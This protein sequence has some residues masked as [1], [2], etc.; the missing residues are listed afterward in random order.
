MT[1]SRKELNAHNELLELLKKK[2]KELASLST[3]GDIERK[4]LLAHNICLLKIQVNIE[5]ALCYYGDYADIYTLD[6]EQILDRRN[7]R[8][9]D[10]TI[11]I[12][13]LTKSLN[14]LKLHEMYLLELNDSHKLSELE[15][16]QIEIENTTRRIA[17][18]EY[19]I[20][21]LSGDDLS[22]VRDKLLDDTKSLG[23][24]ELLKY[25]YEVPVSRTEKILYDIAVD[26]K[27][28]LKYQDCLLE[29]HTAME[30][31]EGSKINHDYISLGM[32]Q[33]LLNDINQKCLEITNGKKGYKLLS[34][35]SCYSAYFHITTI[36]MINSIL[37]TKRLKRVKSK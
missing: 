35:D 25:E 36:N 7:H 4:R 26:G 15:L 33:S 29:Y 37:E 12:R 24:G 32:G 1:N 2:E 34:G 3:D 23:I 31:I 5:S 17:T 27:K 19:D 18:L 13:N 6:D 14:T 22:V 30:L 11:A 9:A 10:V 28:F 16:V 20:L 21:A 8:I